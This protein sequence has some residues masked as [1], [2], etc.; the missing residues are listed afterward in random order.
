LGLLGKRGDERGDVRVRP[1]VLQRDAHVLADDRERRLVHDAVVHG[2]VSFDGEPERQSGLGDELRFATAGLTGGHPV[3]VEERAAERL[4]RPVAVSDRDLEQRLL[5]GDDLR[6]GERHPPPHVDRQR[7]ARERREHPAQVIR[8]GQRD[9]CELLDVD[10]VGQV[11]LEVRQHPVRPV[12]HPRLL[13][14]PHVTDTT[15]R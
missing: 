6:G 12:D 15:R 9:A 14:H 2:S 7:H 3:H 4:G 5:A 8:R 10:F 11:R 13:A 1:V